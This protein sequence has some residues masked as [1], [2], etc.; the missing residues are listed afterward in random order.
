MSAETR[1]TAA[2]VLVAVVLVLSAW[3]TGPGRAGTEEPAASEPF[4]AGFTDPNAAASLEVVEF[5]PATS[6]IRPFRVANRDGRWTIPSHFDYPADGEDR[7]STI[8]GALVNLRRGEVAGE[9]VADHERFRVLDPLDESQTSAEG[10]G[11]R[12]TVRGQ[13]D[14][15]LAD[16]ILGAQVEGRP[17]LRYV[18]VPDERRVFV[19]PL[20]EV[21]ISTK[22][23]DWIERNLLLVQRADIDQ[24]AIRNYSA[25][26]A[27]GSIKERDRTLLSLTGPDE[28]TAEGLRA[29]EA[30]DTFT[31]NLLVTSLV[32]LELAGVVAK[33]PSVA[34]R[35]NQSGG[36][37]TQADVSELATR[38]FYVTSDGRLIASRGEVLVHTRSGIFYA[39]RFGEPAVGSNPEGRYLFI[40]VG[41]D[42]AGGRAPDE[43]T[44]QQLEVLRA[45]FAPWYY[46]VAD[47]AV[48][49]IRVARTELIRPANGTR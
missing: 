29:A 40:S 41:Y 26:V 27:T 43:A 32:D 2:F 36:S 24:I 9:L 39:L 35:L 46:V 38:G 25:D 37:V 19:A 44:R 11:S 14:V 49:K 8:A 34:A 21:E 4:F 48:S 6:S 5:D 47:E 1:K 12:V 15:V 10:R 23:E 33:P 20:G 13:N 31:M 18:R 30:I 45:R 42:A 17:A 16:L 3:A 7:L 22:F 28:W